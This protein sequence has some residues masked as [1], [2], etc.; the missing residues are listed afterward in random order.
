MSLSRTP[1]AVNLSEDYSDSDVSAYAPDPRSPNIDPKSRVAMPVPLSPAADSLDNREA[2]EARLAGLKQIEEANAY[3]YDILI[4]KRQRKDDRT[5][6]RRNLEDQQIG[7]ARIRKN[8]RV[9]ARR[10]PEDAAFDQID[11]AIHEEESV[12]RGVFESQPLIL[13]HH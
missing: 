6:H 3:R 4:A 10:A 7:N 1:V 8:E 13:T 9:Q 2:I 11:R 5:N 12:S